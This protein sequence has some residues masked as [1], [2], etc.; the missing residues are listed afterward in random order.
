MLK[1]TL[2]EALQIVLE[3]SAWDRR[4]GVGLGWGVGG[5][6]GEN[7]EGGRE[8]RRRKKGKGGSS[9]TR[10]ALSGVPEGGDKD[11]K[12]GAPVRSLAAW[13]GSLSQ[14]VQ[15]DKSTLLS[16]GL[17]VCLDERSECPCSSFSFTRRKDIL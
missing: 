16:V 13:D 17:A 15:N 6:E 10:D 4:K 5:V 12:R 9:S 11:E 1:F 7:R 2:H 8:Q 14:M 3:H